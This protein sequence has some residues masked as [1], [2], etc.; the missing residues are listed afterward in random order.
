[1]LISLELAVRNS[2]LLIKMNTFSRNNFC[3]SGWK[4][5]CKLSHKLGW[6][7]QLLKHI[8]ILLKQPSGSKVALLF[9]T[10]VEK[11]LHRYIILR[12]AHVKN[13]FK[14]STYT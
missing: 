9:E 11:K 6:C 12:Y 2:W 5:E 14:K 1:M 13:E 8:I 4:K 10:A 3:D 7:N